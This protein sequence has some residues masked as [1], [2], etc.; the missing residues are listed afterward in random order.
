VKEIKAIEIEINSNCNRSCSYCP[1]SSNSR[2]EQGTMNPELFL[3]ILTEIKNI[4]FTG[5]IS[6]SFYN[7]PL[8]VKNFE[9]YVLQARSILP[10]N[11]FL[12]YTN[13]DLL[14]KS[15]LMDLI[16]N[17][18]N[19]FIVTK[20]ENSA[21]YVF[22]ATF[23]SITA[24]VKKKYLKFQNFTNL[25]LTNRGG[26]LPQIKKDQDFKKTPCSIPLHMLTI[27]NQ[28]TVIPCFEDYHQK[29][30]MGNLGHHTL[31]EIWDSK[32]YIE[33]RKKLI[34]GQ[35][36]DFSVCSDCNRSEMLEIF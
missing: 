36:C 1:N 12:L 3:K 11:H 4:G 34:M 16:K 6:F 10:L 26:L 22:D 19:E 24:D 15:R 2:I 31:K 8:L 17:G 28:G 30:S 7:E 29:N 27:T 21:N 35:R 32:P 13:G 25:K 5:R 18:M 33:F 23:E 20:H 9:D 14:S